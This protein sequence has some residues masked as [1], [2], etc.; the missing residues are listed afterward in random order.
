M[1]DSELL[2]MKLHD[3]SD[4]LED[5]LYESGKNFAGATLYGTNRDGERMMLQVILSRVE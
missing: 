1:K 5:N 4:L 2:Q 3:V